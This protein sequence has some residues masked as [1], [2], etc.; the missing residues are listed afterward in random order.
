MNKKQFLEFIPLAIFLISALCH[1]FK[2]PYNSWPLVLSS[3]I[4][5]CLYFYAAFWL[6]AGYAISLVNRIIAGAALSETIIA[7]LFGLMHWQFWRSFVTIGGVGTVAVLSISLFNRK[8][9]GY[10]QLLYRS[11]FFLVI[12]AATYA[13]RQFGG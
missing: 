4:L 7:L 9:S 6:Y 11:V 5:A 3:G 2:T 10:K 1:V 12:L 8:N 13:Y